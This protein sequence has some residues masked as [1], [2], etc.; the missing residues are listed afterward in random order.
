[1]QVYPNLNK[2]AELALEFLSLWTLFVFF[3]SGKY[4]T[5]RRS[6][7]LAAVRR[8]ATKHK[9]TQRSHDKISSHD[10]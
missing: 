2:Q 7:V 1:M 9:D 6:P 10:F 4:R 3:P 5:S 8:A